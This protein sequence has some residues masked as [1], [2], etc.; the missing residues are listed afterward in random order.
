VLK[1]LAPRA[2]PSLASGLLVREGGRNLRATIRL[3]PAVLSFVYDGPFRRR[4]VLK[5][6]VVRDRLTDEIRHDNSSS[7]GKTKGIRHLLWRGMWGALIK[8]LMAAR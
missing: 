1:Q 4:P 8:E 7:G 3:S 6:S 2:E 5:N